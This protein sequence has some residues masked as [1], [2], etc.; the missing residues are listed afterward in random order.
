[1]VRLPWYAPAVLAFTHAAVAYVG[2]D[3][4]IWPSGGVE[5]ARLPRPASSGRSLSVAITWPLEL[6]VMSCVKGQV[7]LTDADLYAGI[8]G[9]RSEQPNPPS[10]S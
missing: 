4:N 5:E 7:W 9:T 1:M 3:R 10:A 6:Y 2:T 8:H